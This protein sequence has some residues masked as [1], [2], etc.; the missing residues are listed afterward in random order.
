MSEFR[1]KLKNALIQS[2]VLP[3]VKAGNLNSLDL[4]QAIMTTVASDDKICVEYG[5]EFC[6][7]SL[8]PISTRRTLSYWM[9]G[10]NI[11]IS[12]QRDFGLFHIEESP[13]DCAGE[14]SVK[15]IIIR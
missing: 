2:S 13:L 12:N 7:T 15:T 1:Y 6:Q 3:A 4:D 5:S 14:L 9:K 10:S 8:N 11:Q